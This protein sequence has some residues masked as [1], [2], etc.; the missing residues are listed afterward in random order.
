M[1]WE[2]ATLCHRVIV[3]PNPCIHFFISSNTLSA[4]HFLKEAN[5]LIARL[6]KTKVI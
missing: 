4:L 5:F 2:I 1:T 3:L 6:R